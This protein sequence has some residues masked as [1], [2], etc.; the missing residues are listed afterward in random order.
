M[1]VLNDACSSRLILLWG[2]LQNKKKSNKHAFDFAH[3]LFYFVS[4]ENKFNWNV[5][6]SII[7]FSSKFKE[8]M[9][10]DLILYH[11]TER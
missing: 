9:H 8:N 11:K 10:W 7:F 3:S 2:S 4:K 1:E 5:L 6:L